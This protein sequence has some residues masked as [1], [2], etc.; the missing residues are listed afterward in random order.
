M[1]NKNYCDH[2]LSECHTDMHIVCSTA[3]ACLPTITQMAIY[4]SDQL[5]RKESKCECAL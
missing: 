4:F 5:K 1:D 2:H 3:Y